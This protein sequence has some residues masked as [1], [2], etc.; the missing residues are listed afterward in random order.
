VS[1]SRVLRILA[2]VALATGVA[3]L[4]AR[5]LIPDEPIPKP[6]PVDLRDH[7]SAAEIAR[8]R[9]FARPQL[10]IGLAAG[11][12]EAASLIEVVRRRGR[13]S[14]PAG[15]ERPVLRSAAAGALLSSA[16][17]L[18]GLPLRALARR[19]ALAIGLATQPWRGWGADLAKA[20]AIQA[21]FAAG[22]AA[23][24]T[25]MTRRWPRRWWL[26]AAG[27]TVLLGGGLAAL[28]PVVL[29][30]VFNDFTPL[31]E[32]ETRNDVLAL[33]RDA[34]VKVGQVLSMD[35]SRRTTAANAYVSGLGP[36][37][38]VV[39]FDTLLDRYS[40]DE[41]RVVVA[42]ELGHV[43]HRDVLRSLAFAALTAPAG[44]L[45]VQRVSWQLTEQRG[46]PGSLPALALAAGIVSAPIG[47]IA[48]RM[49]RAIERRA[50]LFSLR[51]SDAPEAFVSFERTI[52]LQNV[53]DLQPPRVLSLLATHP[54][55]DERIGGAVR[56]AETRRAGRPAP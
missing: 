43:H 55:T 42:H 27:G 3:E 45:A 2:P 40:R 48:N 30:P 13:R 50:D 46:T 54:P 34:G 44:A 31:P 16:L 39:L 36:T 47:I 52:A 14:F 8:G 11:V 53:A 33:S 26:P 20:S 1:R 21:G 29:D 38:R 10:A 17:S 22:G 51:L 5:L 35:A 9:R 12:L 37:K 7:F 6:A 18:P 19:R 49:S 4:S 15:P 24:V 32:G 23:A 56:Y 41:V 28:A 25:A